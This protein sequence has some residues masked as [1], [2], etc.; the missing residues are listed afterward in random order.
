MRNQVRHAGLVIGAYSLLFGWL[1]ARPVVEG[2]Y[3]A[4]ADLYETFLPAAVSSLGFGRLS[5]AL[6]AIDEETANASSD[7]ARAAR[8]P[9]PPHKL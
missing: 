2:G 5:A 9:I 7:A 3:I 6:R 8:S 4:E 1:F